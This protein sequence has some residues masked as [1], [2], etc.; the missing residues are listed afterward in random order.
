[1]MPNLSG[2]NTIRTLKILN[3]E[4]KIIAVSGLSERKEEALA[5][6]ANTFLPKP[7]TIETLLRTLHSIVARYPLAN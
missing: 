6:G 3:P 4:I 1:M 2:I 5:A 7:Y